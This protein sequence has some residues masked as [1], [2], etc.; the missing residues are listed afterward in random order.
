MGTNGPWAR[1]NVESSVKRK[2]SIKKKKLQFSKALHS[3]FLFS[4]ILEQLRW[5]T[6]VVALSSCLTLNDAISFH[7]NCTQG[8]RGIFFLDSQKQ[9]VLEFSIISLKNHWKWTSFYLAVL[10]STP[11][12]SRGMSARLSFAYFQFSE[13]YTIYYNFSYGNYIIYCMIGSIAIHN[14]LYIL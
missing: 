13:Y 6:Q 12:C 11:M 5:Q 10:L 4:L 1:G 7:Y 2:L 9:V 8:T 3:S 14:F